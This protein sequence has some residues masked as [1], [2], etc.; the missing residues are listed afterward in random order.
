V[1]LTTIDA[2]GRPRPDDRTILETRFTI[3]RP[4]N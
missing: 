3:N 2:S 1:H 4:T